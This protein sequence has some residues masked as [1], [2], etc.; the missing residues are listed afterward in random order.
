[1]LSQLPLGHFMVMYQC[2]AN[3]L[4]HRHKYGP[5]SNSRAYSLMGGAVSRQ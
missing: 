1:M 3:F 4:C 2:I 5:L